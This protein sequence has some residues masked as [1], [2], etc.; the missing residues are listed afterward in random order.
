M[1][2]SLSPLILFSTVCNSTLPLYL[3]RAMASSK[4]PGATVTYWH[5]LLGSFQD[6]T[7]RIMEECSHIN[8][9]CLIQL[10]VLLASHLDPA[11]SGPHHILS[12]NFSRAWF[13]FF[14]TRLNSSSVKFSWVSN[15]V[16]SVVI[17]REVRVDTWGEYRG[18][19][20]IWIYPSVQMSPC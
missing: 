14:L 19:M 8:K 7:S 2:N 13:F 10:C 1:P 5:C 9:L 15:Q 12:C 4:L 17:K 6:V 20:K 16:L 3:G 18:V 11:P